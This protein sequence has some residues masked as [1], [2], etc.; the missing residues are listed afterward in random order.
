MTKLFKQFHNE[1]VHIITKSLKGSEVRNGARYIGPVVIAGFLL[2]EDDTYLY[3][4]AAQD[5]VSDAILR[6]EIVRMYLPVED[7]INA[8]FE[9]IDIP[10]A[11][12]MS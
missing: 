10:P 5:E 8:A 3:L 1:Y 7:L 9:E 6:A 4:G 2:D 11:D 12:E